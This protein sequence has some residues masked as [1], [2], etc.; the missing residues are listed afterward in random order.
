MPQYLQ[1]SHPGLD[2]GIDIRLR[3]VEGRWL[4]TADLGD[5]RSPVGSGASRRQAIRSALS[6]LGQPHATGMAAGIF[7]DA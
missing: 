7:H 5:D 3:R 2:F 1:L 6:P 4:A